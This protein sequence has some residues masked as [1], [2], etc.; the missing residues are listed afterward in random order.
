MKKKKIFLN[1]DCFLLPSKSENFGMS[2]VEA[3]SYG[4]SVLTTEE[5]PWS[6]LRN[7][8]AGKMC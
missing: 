1:S 4:V 3:L 5:T 2:I 8:N 7:I 6:V